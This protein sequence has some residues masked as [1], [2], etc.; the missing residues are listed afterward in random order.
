MQVLCWVPG[1]RKK[2]KGGGGG[3]GGGGE[4]NGRKSKQAANMDKKD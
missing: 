4:T 3:G 1:E 2:L